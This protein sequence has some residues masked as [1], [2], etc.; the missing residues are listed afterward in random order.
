MKKECTNINY[1][2]KLLYFFGAVFVVLGHG[3]EES[4]NLFANWFPYYAFHL[5]LFA[6]LFRLF[7]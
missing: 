1:R 4:L 3:C 2:F 6:F 7:L 5:G